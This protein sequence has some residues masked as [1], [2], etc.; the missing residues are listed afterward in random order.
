MYLFNYLFYK[1]YKLIVFLGNSEFYPEGNAWFVSSMFLWLNMLTLLNFIEIRI[2]RPMSEPFF[3]I[4]FYII[5]L[6]VTYLYFFK[7]SRYLVII[8]TLKKEEGSKKNTGTIMA[9][10]YIV[11]TVVLHLF[12]S[13]E[14]RALSQTSIHK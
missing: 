7:R 9:S 8:D 13:E 5:Y 14:R 10:F 1:V 12:F 2:G 11:M 4:L 3:V 6:I